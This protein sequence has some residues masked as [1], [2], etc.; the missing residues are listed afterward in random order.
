DAPELLDTRLF[1]LPAHETA[2]LLTLFTAAA[3]PPAPARVEQPPAEH[4]ANSTDTGPHV[5]LEVFGAIRITYTGRRAPVDLTS[6][7][8]PKHRELLAFLACHPDGVRREALNE[9]IWPD[10]NPERPYN[11]LHYTLSTLR[12][13]MATATDGQIT[14]LVANTGGR[15]RLDTESVDTDY[16]RLRAAI[17]RLSS[18]EGRRQE[19]AFFLE[20]YRGDLAEDISTLWLDAPR[21]AIRRDMLDAL[22]TLARSE[23]DPGVRLKLLERIRGIDPYAEEA[24]REIMRTQAQSGQRDAIPRTLDLL[25]AKLGEIDEKPD[26]DTVALAGALQTSEARSE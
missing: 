13:A 20:A 2:D 22:D 4:P 6:V 18:A 5:L 12:K 11:N 3:E 7:T 14:N 24:Y 21:E 19:T 23:K 25:S 17:A 15:Y 10:A 8:T 1:T 26:A 16:A 9:A